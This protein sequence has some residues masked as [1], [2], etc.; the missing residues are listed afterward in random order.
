DAVVLIPGTD[1]QLNAEVKTGTAQINVGALAA[2]L[3][4]QWHLGDALLVTEFINP[5]LAKKLIDARIQF[6]DAAGNAYINRWPVHIQ[7]IG[8]RKNQELI[9]HTRK[10][11]GRAFQQTGMKVIF[12]IL[13]DRNLLNA[14]Y[15][16]IA[17]KAQ[18]A[19]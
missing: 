19:L 14:P 4:Q 11:T 3:K 6:M 7:I 12:E 16:Q 15:R 9:G 10:K 17:D 8:N 18:V 5:A 13:K 2:R 1:I